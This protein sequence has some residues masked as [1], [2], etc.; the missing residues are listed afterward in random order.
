MPVYGGVTD[1]AM[2]VCPSLEA[3]VMKAT[4]VEVRV[5]EVMAGVVGGEPAP[6]KLDLTVVYGPWMMAKKLMRP[7]VWTQHIHG[8][9]DVVADPGL[10]AADF[11]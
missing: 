2:M 10:V 1:L 7:K 9:C 6:L 8:A 5:E 11:S 4:W 3:V